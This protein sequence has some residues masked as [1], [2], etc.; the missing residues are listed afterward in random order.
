MDDHTSSDNA[1]HHNDA[2]STKEDTLERLV[3]MVDA[4]SMKN[5]D[6]NDHEVANNEESISMDTAMSI[7]D[8]ENMCLPMQT[9]KNVLEGLG[10]HSVDL[11]KGC[12]LALEGISSLELKQ[13]DTGSISS[14]RKF[15]SLVGRCFSKD[16]KQNLTKTSFED[17][18]KEVY[19]ERGTVIKVSVKGKTKENKD[20]NEDF[21]FRVIAIIDKYY[22]KWFMSEEQKKEWYPNY[23]AKKYRV[24]AVMVYH[25]PVDQSYSDVKV[26]TIKD[27]WYTND[28]FVLL[29][30]SKIKSV[31]GKV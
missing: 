25:D 11:G 29:D 27:L 6:N 22:N 20:V 8:N 19:V 7:Y 18:Q 15:K 2:T 1:V 3:E 28:A 10:N 12:E 26:S 5:T 9:F 13:R 14:D 23:P 31:D 16:A 24:Q 4:V 30:A 17:K 21:V